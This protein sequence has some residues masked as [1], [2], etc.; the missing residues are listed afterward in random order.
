MGVRVGGSSSQTRG[1]FSLV[2]CG[3]LGGIALGRVEVVD[4]VEGE[5]EVDADGVWAT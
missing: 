5:G 4:E 3:I 2:R 1:A